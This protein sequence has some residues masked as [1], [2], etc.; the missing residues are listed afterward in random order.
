M[1]NRAAM[2]LQITVKPSSPLSL[3]QSFDGPA[4]IPSVATMLLDDIMISN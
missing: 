4:P 3:Y 2:A 1:I